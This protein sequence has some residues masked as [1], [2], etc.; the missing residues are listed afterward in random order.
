MSEHDPRLKWSEETQ[1]LMDAARGYA[2]SSGRGYT[3]PEHILLAM[4]HWATDSSVASRAL[5]AATN[6][7]LDDLHRALQV[8]IAEQRKIPK[9][10][11][12][13][14]THELLGELLRRDEYPSN[15]LLRRPT[16][17]GFIG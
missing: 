7:P 14:A 12:Q 4:T 6:L 2:S 3:R 13:I 9:P 11:A 16:S 10:L 5:A 15:E 17:E 8:Q 1:A